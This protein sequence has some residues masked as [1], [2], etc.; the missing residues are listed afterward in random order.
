MA[1]ATVVKC[2]DWTYLHSRQVTRRSVLKVSHIH[3]AVVKRDLSLAAHS[4]TNRIMRRANS[5]RVLRTRYRP[6]AL[7]ARMVVPDRV[8]VGALAVAEMRAVKEAREDPVLQLWSG[9]S[10]SLWVPSGYRYALCT[11]TERSRPDGL[12]SRRDFERPCIAAVPCCNAIG[13]MLD[14][15]S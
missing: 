13:Y 6:L 9:T 15:F 4:S 11:T 12:K 5:W 8:V 7:V 14:Y 1:V 10:P 2:S 3:T